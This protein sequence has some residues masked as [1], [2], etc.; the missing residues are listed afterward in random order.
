M[1]ALKAEGGDDSL[2]ELVQ[3]A[4]RN[5][6]KQPKTSGAKAA[7][8]ATFEAVVRRFPGKAAKVFA[9]ARLSDETKR[10][11][12]GLLT[13]AD[14][15]GRFDEAGLNRW[16]KQLAGAEDDLQATQ[17]IAELE[18]GLE[19]AGGH[20]HPE[21][22]IILG[23]KRGTHTVGPGRSVEITKEMMEEVDV[24]YLGADGKVHAEEVKHRAQALREKLFGKKGD[25]LNLEYL[26][27]M[28][29]WKGDAGDR[30]VTV[31]IASDRGWF[32][33]FMDGPKGLPAQQYL[34]ERKIQLVMAGR[35]LDY[36]EWEKIGSAW[37]AAGK[38]KDG[39][40]FE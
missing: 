34:E 6:P 21:G 8:D 2:L 19:V 29:K 31:V 28:K 9:S 14:E 24:L 26:R 23:A 25:Q 18:R 5:L 13:K 3:T 30:T 10:V 33:V 16:L 20:L 15:S 22:Q 27:R 37:K 4:G 1:A 32:D 17:A 35:S 11:V 36:E 38:P 39:E 12:L 40:L 7:V